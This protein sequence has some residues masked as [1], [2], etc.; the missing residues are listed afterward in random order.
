MVS[1]PGGEGR[2]RGRLSRS[3]DFDRAY[4]DG[5]SHANRYLV[6]YA[7][8]RGEG[9]GE[10]RLGVSVGKKVGG[11]VERNKV[12]RAMREAFWS[13]ADRLPDGYDF[14]LVGRAEVAALVDRAGAGALSE[15]LA[16]LLDEAG[17]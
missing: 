11:A 15:S 13:L 14:V 1:R 9:G 5:S 12:K 16:A 10:V 8:P 4:R 3:G 17:E 7:F 2:K 6:L